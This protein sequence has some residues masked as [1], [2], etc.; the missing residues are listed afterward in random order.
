MIHLKICFII[1]IDDAAALQQSHRARQEQ[2]AQ[3]ES[4]LTEAH[5]L[6]KAAQQGRIQKQHS[7]STAQDLEKIE[8]NPISPTNFNNGTQ[9]SLEN[10]SNHPNSSKDHSELRLNVE[11]LK[12]R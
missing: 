10:S 8:E 4:Q 1:L 12:L 11:S 6:N 3:M 2:R 7:I 5:K 9:P